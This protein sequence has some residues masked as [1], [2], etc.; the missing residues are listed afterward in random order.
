[1]NKKTSKIFLVIGIFSLLAYLVYGVPFTPQGNI[2]LRG[3]Y[4][5]VSG[6]DVNA[7]NVNADFIDGVQTWEHESYPTSCP[8]GSAL[9]SIGNTTICEDNWINSDGN[10]TIN[11]VLIF[12]TTSGDKA[13]LVPEGYKVCLDGETCLHY[14]YYNG[15]HTVIE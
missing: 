13:M 1:M 7:T 5:L 10:D 8:S 3:I 14:V 6:V 15:T 4:S 11:G 9:T 2:N 12:N